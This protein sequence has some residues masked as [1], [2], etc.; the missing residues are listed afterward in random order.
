[1]KIKRLIY[2][3]Q[4]VLTTVSFLS[5]IPIPKW[6]YTGHALYRMGIFFPIVGALLGGIAALVL[7]YSTLFF[8]YTVSVAITLF[9]YGWIT[10]AFHEDALA[11]TADGM[12]G[13]TPQKILAIM[14]DSCIGTYGAFALISSYVLRYAALT[15]MSPATAATSLIAFA[16]VSRLAGVLFLTLAQKHELPPESM[17]RTVLFS[18]RWLC[19]FAGLANTIIILGMIMPDHLIIVPVV[20]LIIPIAARFY[21]LRRIRAITGDCAGFVIYSTETVLYLLAAIKPQ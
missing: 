11:D 2:I 6:G 5:W 13:N 3:L 15:A 21:F 14:R 1:M 18:N 12:G 20:F 16:S 17:N 8:P 9:V 7:S 19:F 10:G 4:L